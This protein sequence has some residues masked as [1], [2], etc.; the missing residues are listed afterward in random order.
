[1][2]I[3]DV[4]RQRIRAAAR[5][6]KPSLIPA[7]IAGLVVYVY[8]RQNRENFQSDLRIDV[9]NELNLIANRLQSEINTNIAALNGFAN[10]I[11]VH[12]AMTP[13][14][15]TVMATKLLLQNPQHLSEV[16]AAL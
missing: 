3:I 10:S 13:D 12:P 11:G 2:K 8:E 1:M 7:A 4:L 15:F 5:F 9:E 6:A 14:D 16:G